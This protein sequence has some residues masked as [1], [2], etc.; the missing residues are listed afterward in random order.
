MK[1]ME[2]TRQVTGLHPL[3]WLARLRR[4]AVCERRR[5]DKTF[6]KCAEVLSVAGPHRPL[7]RRRRPLGQ[8]QSS[9]EHVGLAFMVFMTFMVAALDKQPERSFAAQTLAA[10]G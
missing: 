1:L 2:G 6:L 7:G 8:R 3:A 5:P 9:L 10:R 4:A